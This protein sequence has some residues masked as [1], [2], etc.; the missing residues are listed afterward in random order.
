MQIRKFAVA[1]LALAVVSTGALAATTTNATDMF[2]RPIVQTTPVDGMSPL[3]PAR[4]LWEDVHYGQSP[5]DFTTPKATQSGGNE[6]QA[7]QDQHKWYQ[8]G[9][10]DLSEE[11]EKADLDRQGFPQYN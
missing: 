9:Q 7:A 6:A 1:V 4:I 5:N 11:K 2:G 10:R 3:D 8:A